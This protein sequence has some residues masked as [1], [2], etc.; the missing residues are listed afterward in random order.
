MNRLSDP[1]AAPT[2]SRA[3]SHQG[4]RPGPAG[5]EGGE[6]PGRQPRLRRLPG[7]LDRVVAEQLTEVG[8]GRA[9]TRPRPLVPRHGCRMPYLQLR[10][11]PSEHARIRNALVRWLRVLAGGARIGPGV[12]GWGPHEA[13]VRGDR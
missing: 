12:R 6:P 10:H 5:L 8:R 13:D 11:N 1:S 2:D 7:G 9:V 3:A 4:A